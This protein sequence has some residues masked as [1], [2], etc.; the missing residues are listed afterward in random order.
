MFYSNFFSG[1]SG[2]LTYNPGAILAGSAALFGSGYLIQQNTQQFLCP[3]K[4]NTYITSVGGK[5]YYHLC[6]YDVTNGPSGSCSGSSASA[7]RSKREVA[8]QNHTRAY[9]H[10]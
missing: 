3:T 5:F 10:P 9:I 1:Q 2:T 8:E 4:N 6:G 7:V